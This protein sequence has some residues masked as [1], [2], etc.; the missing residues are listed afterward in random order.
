MLGSIDETEVESLRSVVSLGL[1]KASTPKQSQYFDALETTDEG[2]DFDYLGNPYNNELRD[3]DS[4]NSSRC[5][6][7]SLNSTIDEL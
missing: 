4:P 7:E 5:E 3:S 2:E 6:K 1:S